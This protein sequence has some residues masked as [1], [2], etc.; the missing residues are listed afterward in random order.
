MI[1]SKLLALMDERPLK[2]NQR[3]EI[4]SANTP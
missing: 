3:T 1:T 2:S 4:G